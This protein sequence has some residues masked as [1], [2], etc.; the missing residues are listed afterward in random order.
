VLFSLPAAWLVGGAIGRLLSPRA[1]LPAAAAAF[2]I[3]LGALVCA[4][5]RLPVPLTAALAI[6]LGLLN[7]SWNGIELA[8]ARAGGVASALGVACATF[9][10]IALLAALVSCLRAPWSRI[11]VRV[12][13]SWIAA[14]GL[15]LLGWSLRA[16]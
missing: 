11:A 9:V 12:A 13:G 1:A 4:D 16:A 7:G 15:L 14:I 10:V 3:A 2:T 5:A 6:A 8:R